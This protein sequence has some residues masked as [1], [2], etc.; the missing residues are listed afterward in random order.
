MDLFQLAS[1]ERTAPVGLRGYDAKIVSTETAVRTGDF[2]L[3]QQQFVEDADVNVIVRRFGISGQLPSR[4]RGQAMYGDFT[5]ITDFE[6]ARDV[7]ARA[8]AGFKEL[9]AQVRDQFGNDPARLI[10]YAQSV[11]EEEFIE[12]IRV[13]AVGGVE[14]PPGVAPVVE[15][16]APEAPEGA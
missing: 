8:E 2:T 13:P 1:V 14:A 5:G 6:S 9:P 15:S 10:A 11:S 16:P 4:A 3:T 12:R 7:V